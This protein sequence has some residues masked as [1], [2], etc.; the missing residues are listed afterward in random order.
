MRRRVERAASRHIEMLSARA[1]HIVDKIE[2]ALLAA[3]GW[4]QKYGSCAVAKEHAGRS[5]LV[6]QNRSHDVT[7]N[8]EGFFVGARANKL[9]CDSHRVQE[10]RARRG[11]VKSPRAFGAQVVLYQ[12][13]RRGKHHVRRHAGHHDQV[14][15]GSRNV[16]CGE[17]LPRRGRSEV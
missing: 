6:I 15:F 9:R 8:R 16:P 14:N 10:S 3:F 11:K 4:F 1:V 12:A 7:T 5:V 13:R 17:D 2:N